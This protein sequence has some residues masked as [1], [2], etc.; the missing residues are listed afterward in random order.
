MTV[1]Q[2]DNQDGHYQGESQLFL[3]AEPNSRDLIT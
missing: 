2:R 1:L 3:S